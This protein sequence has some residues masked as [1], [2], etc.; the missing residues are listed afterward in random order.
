DGICRVH[1][2]SRPL[3]LKDA[4][5]G[6][7]H[8]PLKEDP[9]S[10]ALK[11]CRLLVACEGNRVIGFSGSH[12]SFLGWL[13]MDPEYAGRGIGKKL[14]NESLKY[15]GPHTWTVT[16][17]DNQSARKLYESAGF[18]VKDTF[19]SDDEGFPCKVCKMGMD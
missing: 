6:Y 16:L 2:R 3:E 7:S 14:L 4:P 19:V 11:Q 12:E 18:T 17:A 5:S 10:E 15:T 9:E 1:D 13:Y 8:T